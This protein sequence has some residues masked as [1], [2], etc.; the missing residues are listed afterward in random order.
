M[1]QCDINSS[2]ENLC[3]CVLI[4]QTLSNKC[5]FER[6]VSDERPQETANATSLEGHNYS[7]VT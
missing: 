2:A 4:C 3:D 6:V 1:V 7:V 5:I